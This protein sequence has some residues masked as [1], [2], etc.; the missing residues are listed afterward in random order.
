MESLYGFDCPALDESLKRLDP[1]GILQ[2]ISIEHAW[3]RDWKSVL[4]LTLPAVS[5]Y[6]AAGLELKYRGPSLPLFLSVLNLH[7]QLG[8]TQQVV[9]KQMAYQSGGI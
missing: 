9:A 4:I 2:K 1:D 6:P 8:K 7:S 3:F 5:R